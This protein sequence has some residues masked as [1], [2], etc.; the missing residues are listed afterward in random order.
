MLI[1]L[2]ALPMPPFH[3]GMMAMEGEGAVAGSLARS[4]LIKAGNLIGS[5]WP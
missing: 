2:G 5:P 1:G 3:S 4:V